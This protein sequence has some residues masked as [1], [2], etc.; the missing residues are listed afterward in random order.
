MQVEGSTTTTTAPGGV[1]PLPCDLAADQQAQDQ[2]FLLV[3]GLA[4]FGFL[5][6]FYL[7]Y[8]LWA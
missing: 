2:T 4:L 3:V 8:R 7:A 5:L 6:A 1:Y